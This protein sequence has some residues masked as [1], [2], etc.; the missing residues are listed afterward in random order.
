MI[1]II[2]IVHIVLAPNQYFV[3]SQTRKHKKE[4]NINNK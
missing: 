2:I 1:L 4:T 3:H